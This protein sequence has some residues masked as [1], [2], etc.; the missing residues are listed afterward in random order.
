MNKVDLIKKEYLEGDLVMSA[1]LQNFLDLTDNEIK[2]LLEW[3]GDDEYM[4][5]EDIR[6]G[7]V[8]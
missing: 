1:L 2:E 6:N 4:T 3:S 7:G 5:V 8:D